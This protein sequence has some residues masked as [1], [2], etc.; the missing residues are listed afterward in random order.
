MNAKNSDGDT[1]LMQAYRN[2]RR[3]EALMQAYLKKRRLAEGLM[4]AFGVDT[5]LMRT[6]L[7]GGYINVV[8]LLLKHKDIDVN[9][10]NSDGYTVF[11]WASRDGHIGVVKLLLEHKDTDVNDKNSD[12][13][14]ALI[15][16]SRNGH[17][18]V[19]ELLLNA[20]S[21]YGDTALMRTSIY[22]DE[23]RRC[24]RSAFRKWH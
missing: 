16:A 13:N 19:V 9:A 20:T 17:A 1:A 10:K 2:E 12:G 21:S 23:T 24:S 11:M 5:A 15:W 18:D 6:Y 8:K 7:N 4:Q 3:A 14:T 22:G